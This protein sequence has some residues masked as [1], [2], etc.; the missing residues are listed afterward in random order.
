MRAGKEVADKGPFMPWWVPPWPLRK[1]ALLRRAA[2]EGATLCVDTGL[3]V[4]VMD[5]VLWKFQVFSLSYSSILSD[6]L[7]KR[8]N[9]L[10]W[11]AFCFLGGFLLSGILVNRICIATL[12]GFCV[13]V[14]IAL[15]NK[16]CF[17]LYA[18]FL[19]GR[20]SLSL[21]TF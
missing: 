4:A 15:E 16:R 5:Y 18:I 13:L 3:H 17:A 11:K 8:R 2:R 20:P 19:A 10:N 14:T 6:D 12:V 21:N 1:K 9:L 7:G